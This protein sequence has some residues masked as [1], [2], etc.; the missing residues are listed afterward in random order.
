MTSTKTSIANK[1]NTNGNV[2]VIDIDIEL[3]SPPKRKKRTGKSKAVKDK[4]KK[5]AIEKLLKIID[6]ER[7]RTLLERELIAD[8][9]GYIP[10]ISIPGMPNAVKNLREMETNLQQYALKLA[11]VQ[12]RLM[13]F[14]ED[15]GATPRDVEELMRQ[16]DEQYPNAPMGD[17]EAGLGPESQEGQESRQY[18]YYQP[19]TSQPIRER[20]MPPQLAPQQ[21]FTISP[22]SQEVS[23]PLPQPAW[24]EDVARQQQIMEE[25]RDRM[26]KP[27]DDDPDFDPEYPGAN[28]PSHPLYYRHNFN[29][30][31]RTLVGDLNR[32]LNQRGSMPIN[33]IRGLS[34]NPSINLGISDMPFN[35]L[36]DQLTDA[37]NRAMELEET[38]K[39]FQELFDRAKGQ[40]VNTVR[41]M[42]SGNI[43]A[44]L[45]T[46]APSIELVHDLN[47]FID[48]LERELNQRDD[49]EETGEDPDQRP[50][51]GTY[52]G[53]YPSRPRPGPIIDEPTD[54]DPD[55]EG[56]EFAP[57][58][59]P[60][61]VVE[62]PE[63]TPETGYQT[64]PE[65]P[66]LPE[67]PTEKTLVSL[68]RFRDKLAE[69][70]DDNIEGLTEDQETFSKL[71]ELTKRAISDLD[72]M[73]ADIWTGFPANLP[74]L[75][76]IGAMGEQELENQRSRILKYQTDFA[77]E[78][79][80]E[81]RGRI[82]NTLRN[83]DEQLEIIR[84]NPNIPDEDL[85]SFSGRSGQNVT[86]SIEADDM[87]ITGLKFQA[88]GM[89]FPS[90]VMDDPM[91]NRSVE[92][93]LRMGITP[94]SLLDGYRYFINM[95]RQQNPRF[96]IQGNTDRLSH[97][98]NRAIPNSLVA[99]EFNQR[100]DK[101][102]DLLQSSTG[103]R[104]TIPAPEPPETPPEDRTRSYR[105][106]DASYQAASHVP[107][108]SP[109][110]M[111]LA[112]KFVVNKVKDL[113]E[114]PANLPY[115]PRDTRGRLPRNIQP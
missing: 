87:E 65:L 101:S 102:W 17:P 37:E 47:E 92:R 22:P 4:E 68:N 58:P 15:R 61:P 21:P 59:P 23:P 25:M 75:G 112:G 73:G 79:D 13:D 69:Y 51:T 50:D 53:R 84:E 99:D 11:D 95:E 108:P 18:H 63:P 70:F 19:S 88:E 6:W 104:P 16:V 110:E 39:D 28:D 10:P 41:L 113:F 12:D 32:I 38:L 2:N 83:I 40:E 105:G 29:E 93:L 30:R 24:E 33:R 42:E 14:Y 72:D 106:Q 5:A 115:D 89:G 76:A 35:E 52:G 8:H 48:Q 94:R 109:D 45:N 1:D 86:R 20:T 66:P 114:D 56:E 96:V 44:P 100:L 57:T 97:F 7:G 64:P 46:Y 90:D 31:L 91:V 55:A 26:K 107:A 27:D 78:L 67:Y 9:I 98:Y 49:P 80:L 111:R 82:G 103:R 71:E 54:W 85:T 43:S 36:V 3:P 77:A 60:S 34:Q 74:T 81:E 62:Q